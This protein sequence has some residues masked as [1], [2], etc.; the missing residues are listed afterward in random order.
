MNWFSHLNGGKDEVYLTFSFS[1]HK[2][3]ICTFSVN[4]G[5][6]PQSIITKDAFKEA[7]LKMKEECEGA[8]WGLVSKLEKHFLEH[9]LMTMLGVVDPWLLHL[10]FSTTSS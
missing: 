2:Y 1:E 6:C 10:L 4:G 8:T 7:F 5:S 9:K 3:P